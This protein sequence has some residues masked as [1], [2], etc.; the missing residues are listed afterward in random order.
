MVRKIIS[1]FFYIPGGIFVHTVCLLAFV[2]IP[3]VGAFKFAIIAGFSITAL[4]FL[5]IGAVIYR[6]QNW[7]Y[8]IGIVLLSAVSFTL[9]GVITFICILVTPNIE[10]FFP[11]NYN[12]AMFNDYSSGFFVMLALAS[13]GGFLFKMG[14]RKIAETAILN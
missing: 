10:E 12:F 9:L 8:S 14:Q 13:L 6:F 2:N 1:M 7:K 11:D 5:V 3:Q 4:F